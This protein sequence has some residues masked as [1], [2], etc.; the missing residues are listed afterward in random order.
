[1]ICRS[2]CTELLSF[3][4][5]VR[6]VSS[7]NKI[8]SREL[9]T[10]GRSLIQMNNNGPKIE[11]CGTP[12]TMEFHDEQAPLTITRCCLPF[13]YDVIQVKAGPLYQSFLS[14]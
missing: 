6:F 7:A 3:L 13:K 12:Q 8:T 11:P 1:M 4:I 2:S 14:F 5:A 9:Q 10:V